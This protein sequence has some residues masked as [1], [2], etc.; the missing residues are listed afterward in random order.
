MKWLLIF[1]FSNLLSIYGMTIALTGSNWMGVMGNTIIQKPLNQ[2]F[3]PG[4]HD[5]GTYYL[6][7][8][9]AKGQDYSE[10]INLLKFLG[11]GYVITSIAKNWAQAQDRSIYQQ[12]T[13]GIRYLDLRVTYRDSDKDFY[14]A[15]G[16]FGPKFSDVLEQIAIFLKRNPREIVV[17]LIGDMHYMGPPELSD[18]NHQRLAELILQAFPDKFIDRKNFSG[19]EMKVGHAWQKDKQVF[20]I[21]KNTTVTDSIREFWPKSV[22]NNYWANSDNTAV[23]KEK[24]EINMNK[25]TE[26]DNGNKFF[27]TQSQMTPSQSTIAK[28]L[29]PIGSRY[30]SLKDMAEDVA[31]Q[32][33]RWLDEWRHRNPNIIIMDFVNEHTS[34]HIYLLNNN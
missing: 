26:N 21:Y 31:K 18:Y 32:F 17:M 13:D 29:I 5:S 6:E 28:S 7:H 16:L 24:L 14:I 2:L 20:L 19:P 27:V 30:R 15:H 33:P 23:L 3:I 12:L 25:R 11:V 10:N 22:I 34:K 8:K 4:S 1:S 9:F